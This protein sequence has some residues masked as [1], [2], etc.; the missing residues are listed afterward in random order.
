MWLCLLVEWHKIGENKPGQTQI[1]NRDGWECS[2]SAE[3][4]PLL[5]KALG[6]IPNTESKSS[7]ADSKTCWGSKKMLGEA[8]AQPHRQSR[9]LLSDIKCHALPPLF[10]CIGRTMKV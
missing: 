4:L 3:R 10:P 1:T 6:P 7:K 5:H 8:E 9:Q 2:P